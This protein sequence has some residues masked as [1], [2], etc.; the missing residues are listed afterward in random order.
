MAKQTNISEYGEHK[1]GDEVYCKT[2]PKGDFSFGKIQLIHIN[3][4]NPPCFTFGCVTTGACKL[5]MFSDIIKDPT[6]AQI[7]KVRRRSDKLRRKR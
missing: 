5:A 1:I 3:D 4:K 7:E 2:Y 6:K